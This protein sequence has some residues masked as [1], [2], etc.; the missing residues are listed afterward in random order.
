[1]SKT[2]SLWL[3]GLAFILLV[4][5]TYAIS[6][7]GKID[8]PTQS[9][10]GLQKNALISEQ[11]SDRL[12]RLP[13]IE[14][15]SSI[16]AV[17]IGNGVLGRNYSIEFTFAD[18]RKLVGDTES[19]YDDS[20][21]I[22]KKFRADRLSNDYLQFFVLTDGEEYKVHPSEGY[23]RDFADIVRVGYLRA[24]NN[25]IIKAE[26]EYGIKRV[27]AARER[28]AKAQVEPIE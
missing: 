7:D 26:W 15:V 25:D 10:S 11:L 22:P 24:A 12:K 17:K 28:E 21:G 3:T 14:K 1:M 6:G 23:F 5:F 9:E 20:E 19:Y 2:L 13:G 18:G 8:F 16:S 27:D 4:I